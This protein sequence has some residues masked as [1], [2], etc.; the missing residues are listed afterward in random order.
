M[1]T[2]AARYRPISDYGLIGNRHTCALVGT[3][4]SID[5]CCLPHLDSPSVFA[6]VLDGVRGGRWRVAPAGAA[7]VSR[8][9]LG[10]SPV[11][12]TV[13]RTAGGVLRLRDFLPIRGGRGEEASWSSHAIVRMA[14]C[15][16][17]R[18]ELELEWSPRPNYARD[19][20]DVRRQE[21]DFIACAQTGA[22]WLAGLPPLGDSAVYGGA[23]AAR[24]PLRAGERLDLIS[25]W[26]AAVPDSPVALA[27]RYLEETLAWWRRWEESCSI[28]PAVEPW[29]ELVLRSGM[30]LKLLTNERTGAIAA[31]PTASLPEEI[32]GIRNWDYRYC[33][34]RDSS[35]ISQAFVAL[36]H[37]DDGIAFLRFLERAAQQHRDPARVQVVY[38]LDGRTRLT[39]YNLGHLDGYRDSRPVRIGND[40]AVQRQ[41]DVYGELLEAAHDLLRI[42]ATLSPEQ[43]SWLQG[44]A[45]YVCQVWRLPDRGIWEVRGPEQHFTYSKLM[46]W[47][48]LDRALRIA[49]RF[50]GAPSADLWRRERTAIRRAIVEE[51][52]DP[53]RRTFVQSFGSRALDASNLLIPIVGFLP[54]TDP[55][56]QGTIDATIRELTEAGLVHRYRVEDTS[57]GVSG[58]EGAFGICT[59]WLAIALALA[60]RVPE[61]REIFEGM[62]A[63]VNDLGLYPEEIDPRTGEFLG[64]F[65]Q[66]FTHV[67][68]INAAQI[69]GEAARVQAGAP[70]TRA[71]SAEAGL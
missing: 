41:L 71:R 39:E 19:D 63:R 35:M 25:G 28:E 64:N 56:V 42:G 70:P 66:A 17:G 52:Y 47:V 51:G 20:V 53:V 21:G 23:V 6:A 30:V 34:V 50:G 31:A 13:F 36:G 67:G 46:C 7:E 49:H 60:G 62:V 24:V 58:A 27:E 1:D 69:V 37:H 68:L 61:A 11:L 9:Y 32:G 33:W 45:D 55:R 12:E 57:D 15:L 8:S 44:I 40:A 38:G 22:V 48:A 59:F 3:D 29:R 5:W 65:P 43:W 18:L 2:G 4:G 16:E 14:E 54:A 26:G 10:A